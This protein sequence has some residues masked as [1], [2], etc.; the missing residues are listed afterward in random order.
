MIGETVLSY[1]INK[2]I[3]EGGMGTVYLG[4]HE[5]LN[6]KVAIKVLNPV[7]TGDND[8]RE[9][10][11]NEAITLSKLN[12]TNIVTLFD[13]ADIGTNLFLIM[14]FVE[15]KPLDDLITNDIGAIPEVRCNKIFK[16]IL[17]GFAYAHTK[18]IVHRDIKP[19]NIILQFDD[20]PKILDF[21]I[22]KIIEGDKKLTK[23]GT[24]MGSVAYMSPEQ[25]LGK[26]V[27]H[28]S[29]IYSLGV[30]YFE[31]LTGKTPYDL[32][33]KSEYEIQHKIVQDTLPS[34]K[35]FNQGLN[36]NYDILIGK[37]TAK[38]PYDRYN[39]C[40]EFIDAIDGQ[41]TSLPSS[42]TIIQPQLKSNQ[43]V[44]QNINNNVQPDVKKN[45]NV[46]YIAG[47][48]II[49]ILVAGFIYFLNKDDS[50]S[51]NNIITT[52][53]NEQ[54]SSGNTKTN[55]ASKITEN[56]CEIFVKTWASIQTNKQLSDYASMYDP[57]FYGIK[58]TKSGK[59]TNYGYSDWINNRTTMYNKATALSITY[60]DL[61]TKITSD[62]TA[63]VS[64]RQ[65]YSSAQYSDEGH[66]IL[67]LKKDS[68]GIIKITYEELIYSTVAGD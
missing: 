66:K 27:D 59:T 12:H 34:V 18:G 1:K 13:F 6:R 14:E 29:D 60:T 41:Y 67:R 33:N 2:K 65:F 7:L 20:T 22:A 24:R 28:R 31:M 19:S 40:E 44:Y 4:V 35:A 62:N 49:I 45:N 30:T 57:S 17:T 56:E 32:D 46:I 39:S 58:R 26:D 36:D 11:I 9:R 48:Y 3:G 55:T 21:G 10:F 50:D 63:E 53:S 38:N 5:K 47:A 43:T 51:N 25:V 23:T 64:F 61:K 54:T 8:I 52:K 15:G 16:Q 68:N 37:A 42:K